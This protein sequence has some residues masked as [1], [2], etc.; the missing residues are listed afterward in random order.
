MNQD[1][2]EKLDPEIREPL[3]RMLE[4]MPPQD[5]SDLPAA[6]ENSRKQM[7]EMRKLMPEIKGLVIEDRM[8]PGPAGDVSDSSA[9]TRMRRLLR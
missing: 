5:F 6:R 8:I 4:S 3:I 2:T 9:P 1:L 7:E